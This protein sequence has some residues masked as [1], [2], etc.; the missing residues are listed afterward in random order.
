MPTLDTNVLVRYLVKDDARQTRKAAE[1]IGG[2]T[3]SDQSLF[4]PISVVLETEWVLRSVYG[5]RKEA[6][7]EVL[8]SLLETKEVQMSDE[9]AIEL[10]VHFFRESNVDF[11]DCLHAALA[12]IHDMLPMVTFDRNAARVEGVQLL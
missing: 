7:I 10:S 2:H 12:H 9:A 5:F 6:F 1:Y 4:I 8:V 3:N 11:A